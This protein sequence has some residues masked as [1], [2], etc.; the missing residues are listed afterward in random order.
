MAQAAAVTRHA[1]FENEGDRINTG[2]RFD[3]LNRLQEGSGGKFSFENNV[4]VRP[5][6]ADH[7]VVEVP[8]TIGQKPATI[9][10]DSMQPRVGRIVF[11][12]AAAGGKTQPARDFTSLEQLQ[13]I[14]SKEIEAAPRTGGGV[15]PGGKYRAPALTF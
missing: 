13:G 3:L 4:N 2:E 6:D 12:A 1:G 9:E 11:G 5:H 7:G 10:F 14:L 15:A 8:V